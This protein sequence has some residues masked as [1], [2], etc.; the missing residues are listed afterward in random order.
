MLGSGFAAG[1]A[2]NARPK[3]VPMV[4]DPMPYMLAYLD[5]VNELKND[6]REILLFALYME[7]IKNKGLAY[8]AVEIL[9]QRPDPWF[10]PFASCD[11]CGQT[12]HDAREFGKSCSNG[13]GF[14]REACRGTYRLNPIFEKPT[15]A[16]Q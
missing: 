7:S 11:W 3:R 15:Q 5:G 1:L 4:A 16:S 13:G 10:K 12:T 2:I 9:R 8:E 14:M 6:E